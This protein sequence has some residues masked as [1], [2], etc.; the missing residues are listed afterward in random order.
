MS[1]VV[2]IRCC[3]EGGDAGGVSSPRDA[4]R[5]P[6][7]QKGRCLFGTGAGVPRCEVLIDSCGGG[8]A[9]RLG[10]LTLVVH[11]VAIT[12]VLNFVFVIL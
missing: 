12:S 1:D 11:I 6:G 10:T 5:G 9:V 3:G 7:E 2:S 4:G 8:V